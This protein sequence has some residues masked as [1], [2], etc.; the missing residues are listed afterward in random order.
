MNN[1]FNYTPNEPRGHDIAWQ[2]L[3]LGVVIGF[4]AGLGLG[5]VLANLMWSREV[6]KLRASIPAL[7]QEGVDAGLKGEPPISGK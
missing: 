3:R 5:M 7:V 6:D 2:T 1:A 4:V